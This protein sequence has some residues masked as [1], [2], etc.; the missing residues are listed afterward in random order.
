M[1]SRAVVP[2][3][4]LP[5]S[6]HLFTMEILSIVF[7]VQLGPICSRRNARKKRVD[8]LESQARW[9]THVVF[10]AGALACPLFDDAAPTVTR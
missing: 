2:G 6:V 3:C 1:F 5:E 8:R 10:S 9:K 4:Y 7:F